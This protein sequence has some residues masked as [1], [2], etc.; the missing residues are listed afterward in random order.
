MRGRRLTML[1][2]PANHSDLS[3]EGAVAPER[4]KAEEGVASVAAARCAGAGGTVRST[5]SSPPAFHN[6]G[7]AVYWV[8]CGRCLQRWAVF[9][10]PVSGPVNVIFYAD[11]LAARRRSHVQIT[12]MAS[13]G[14]VHVGNLLGCV[15]ACSASAAAVGEAADS[16]HDHHAGHVERAVSRASWCGRR[17]QRASCSA[18]C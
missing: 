2:R 5:P 4:G 7:D 10:K 15:R 3:S 11:A 14:P 17:C 8:P 12:M 16:Q 6:C 9:R 13:Q 1:S 18:M